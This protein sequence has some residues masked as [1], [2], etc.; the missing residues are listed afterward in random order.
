M[1][2]NQ[3]SYTKTIDAVIL[4]GGPAP[5]QAS[6]QLDEDAMDALRAKRA[7]RVQDMEANLSGQEVLDNQDATKK[8][9]KTVCGLS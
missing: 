7:Q 5:Q 2:L 9:L 6:T 4:P 1:G 3:A 8:M